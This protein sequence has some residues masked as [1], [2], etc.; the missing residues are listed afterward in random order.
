MILTDVAVTMKANP[1]VVS[2][3]KGNHRGTELQ[4][5]DSHVI[6]SLRIAN[7]SEKDFGKYACIAEVRGES[8]SEACI[9][10]T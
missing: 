2:A 5:F 7:V 9:V 10:I 1:A 8:G 6:F 4:E 3:K